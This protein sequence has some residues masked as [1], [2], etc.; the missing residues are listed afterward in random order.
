MCIRDRC[1]H[2]DKVLS[3]INTQSAVG[4]DNVVYNLAKD[5][6]QCSS[7]SKPTTIFK[8]DSSTGFVN[9]KDNTYLKCLICK[10]IIRFDSRC[11]PHFCDTCENDI[12]KISR[13]CAKMCAY[14]N[15]PLH[16]SSLKS[17]DKSK[18][19]NFCKLH[20]NVHK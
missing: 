13:D 15:V 3:I 14:C 17:S 10:N 9:F 6:P 2:C 5:R 4:V 12:I 18:N 19:I 1:L 8:A 11:F 20:R 16:N 7:C